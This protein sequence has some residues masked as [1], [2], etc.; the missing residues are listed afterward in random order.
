M[1]R[2]GGE[3]ELELSLQQNL[4]VLSFIMEVFKGKKFTAYGSEKEV[5]KRGTGPNSENQH[6]GEV[7]VYKFGPGG[8]QEF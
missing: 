7:F 2:W 6:L 3:F 4:H 8:W 5:H 1:P